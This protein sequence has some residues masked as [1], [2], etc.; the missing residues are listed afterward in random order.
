MRFAE[1]E[2][3]CPAQLGRSHPVDWV[4]PRLEARASVSAPSGPTSRS[5]YEPTIQPPLVRCLLRL[6]NMIAYGMWDL[7]VVGAMVALALRW[8]LRI[9]VSPQRAACAGAAI[10]L[11]QPW[12]TLTFGSLLSFNSL[13]SIFLGGGVAAALLAAVQSIS[14]H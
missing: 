13:P 6:T 5:R 11:L 3:V 4:E 7:M 2:P 10:A 1:E 12:V 9:D 14:N 8:L